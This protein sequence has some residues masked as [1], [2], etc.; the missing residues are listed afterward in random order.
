[1]VIEAKEQRLADLESLLSE[2]KHTV[3]KLGSELDAIGGSPGSLG[4]GKTRKELQSEIEEFKAR[5]E[6]LENGIT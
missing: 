5:V 6:V 3:E 2:Y 4:S 1:M